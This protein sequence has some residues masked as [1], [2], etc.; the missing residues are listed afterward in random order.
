M[1]QQAVTL[2]I[3]WFKSQVVKAERYT[4]IINAFPKRVL[5]SSCFSQPG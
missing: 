3:A 5:N 1:R 4:P 2:A